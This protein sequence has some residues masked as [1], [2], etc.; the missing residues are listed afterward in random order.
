[1]PTL[2]L[3]EIARVCLG[4]RLGAKLHEVLIG[5][6]EVIKYV[7]NDTILDIAAH[8]GLESNV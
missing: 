7:L 6:P 8:V 2:L 1:V 5:H 4:A 3:A